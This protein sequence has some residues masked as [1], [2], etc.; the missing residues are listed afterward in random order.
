M[1]EGA[2]SDGTLCA[3]SASVQWPRPPTPPRAAS[4]K[5]MRTARSTMPSPWAPRAERGSGKDARAR[6]EGLLDSLALLHAR[7]LQ[8]PDGQ[9]PAIVYDIGCGKGAMARKFEACGC[10]VIAC[11][12]H[13]PQRLLR[14]GKSNGHAGIEVL[15][16][17][18]CDIKWEQYPPAQL[19]YSRRFLHYLRFSEAVKLLRRLMAQAPCAAYLSMPGIH[20][21]LNT[22]G[23]YVPLEKRFLRLDPAIAR[24]HHITRRVCLYGIP[25]ARRL[26]EE[27]NMQIQRLWL[28]GFGHVM[29]IAFASGAKT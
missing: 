4:K 17:H 10:H 18:A 8:R 20:S 26:A 23:R 25:D 1:S 12:M 24:K 5:L 22:N 21:E 28:S 7:G 6:R 19:L 13:A 9:N 11:D 3:K 16:A 29:M 15:S 14:Q 27:S 2:R